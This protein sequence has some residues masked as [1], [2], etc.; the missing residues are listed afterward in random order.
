MLCVVWVGHSLRLRSGQ[1]LS[2]KCVH[3]RFRLRFLVLSADGQ[4]CPSHTSLAFH[5]FREHL[6][7]VDGNE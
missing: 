4:E 3:W 1:A 6:V 7:R 5:K 2:D